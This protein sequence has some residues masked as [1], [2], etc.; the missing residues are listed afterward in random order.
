MEK[1]LILTEFLKHGESVESHVDVI[2]IF[3]RELVDKV[4]DHHVGLILKDLNHKFLFDGKFWLS[5]F[6]V[7]EVTVVTAIPR[8]LLSALW[9][10]LDLKKLD[11]DHGERVMLQFI[12]KSVEDL[13]ILLNKKIGQNVLF[14]F[15]EK[16][17]HDLMEVST[18]DW[19]WV[20]ILVKEGCQLIQKSIILSLNWLNW[21]LFLFV[22]HR[23]GFCFSI[24]SIGC[25]LSFIGILDVLIFFIVL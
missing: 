21:L 7:F 6:F 16:L 15:K 14:L 20:S 22:G 19:K 4:V 1:S 11:K 18:Q 12:E 10:N 17:V 25:L 2:L 5:L 13:S 8:F 9:L 3:V 24:L 23:V